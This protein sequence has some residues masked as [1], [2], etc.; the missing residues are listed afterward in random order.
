MNIGPY[1]KYVHINLNYTDKKPWHNLEP[2]I[3]E[4][5]IISKDKK[6]YYDYIKKQINFEDED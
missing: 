1:A 5:F 2:E 6:D 4:Q 3:I